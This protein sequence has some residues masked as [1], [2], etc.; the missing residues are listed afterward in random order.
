MAQANSWEK[1]LESERQEYATHS[2][3]LNAEEARQGVISGRV[4]MVLAVSL[5]LVVA[6]FAVVFVVG[7]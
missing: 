6:A 3:L 5:M 2:P 4:R 7:V 1:P